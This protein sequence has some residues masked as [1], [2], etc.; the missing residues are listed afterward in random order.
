MLA[1]VSSSTTAGL[2]GSDVSL[3]GLLG[4]GH[5]GGTGTQVGTLGRDSPRGVTCAT[6]LP[7]I[8]TCF[9]LGVEACARFHHRRLAVAVETTTFLEPR[10]TFA[11]M[12]AVRHGPHLDKI[13]K[14]EREKGT[15]TGTD[16]PIG[17]F[18]G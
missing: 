9:H 10:I 3:V 18:Q 5:W 17:S 2:G 12:Q 1:S 6:L 11:G 8:T 16:I 4:G 15:I 7:S 14:K 13:L